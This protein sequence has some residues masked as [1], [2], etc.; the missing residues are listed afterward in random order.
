MTNCAARP[1]MKLRL[2]LQVITFFFFACNLSNAA[3]TPRFDGLSLKVH[4]QYEA[5]RINE[6]ILETSF[7]AQFSGGFDRRSTAAN[8]TGSV[9]RILWEVAIPCSATVQA[10]LPASRRFTL[11]PGDPAVSLVRSR[12]RSRVKS[13]VGLG[14]TFPARSIAATSIGLTGVRDFHLLHGNIAAGIIT[15]P[16]AISASAQWSVGLPYRTYGDLVFDPGDL[17]F[18][19][20]LVKALNRSVSVVIA[21]RYQLDLPT[22][23]R[24]PGSAV[25]WRSSPTGEGELALSVRL[26]NERFALRF[27]MI[28][29]LVSQLSTILWEVSY[30]PRART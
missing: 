28:E 17:F 5:F 19:V 11:L 9:N 22:C 15:D 12:S 16:A 3:A 4:S 23:A 13:S 2:G 20:G 21:Y 24:F 18:S 8:K 14:Y 1:P 10:R 7:I 25:R 26:Q 27:E 6:A 30:E 29:A